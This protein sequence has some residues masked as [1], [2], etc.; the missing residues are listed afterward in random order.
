MDFQPN[1]CSLSLPE[2][3]PPLSVPRRDVNARSVNPFDYSQGFS[4]C[5]KCC[6]RSRAG[7]VE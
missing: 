3:E 1:K 2:A 6:E 4:R 5:L 7:K